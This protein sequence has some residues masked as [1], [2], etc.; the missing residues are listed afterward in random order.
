MYKYELV[1]FL[2]TTG[3]VCAVCIA[4]SFLQMLCSCFLSNAFCQ[5]FYASVVV[6]STALLQSLLHPLWSPLLA[7]L[8]LLH[9]L[10]ASY[11][12]LLLS[13]VSGRWNPS[14]MCAVTMA[15]TLMRSSPRVFHYVT[16]ISMPPTH[17]I[18]SSHGL[19][20]VH[21]FFSSPRRWEGTK[22]N[23]LDCHQIQSFN[24]VL[25]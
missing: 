3:Q 10:S 15:P 2:R 18:V 9:T 22:E 13:W 23:G 16:L 12:S 20:W 24:K 21:V 6:Q 17:T 11:F 25:F 19:F 4:G 8:L 1:W 14:I 5:S 7:C